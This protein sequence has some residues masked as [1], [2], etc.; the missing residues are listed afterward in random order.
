M[1]RR[2]FL[3]AGLAS[4]VVASAAAQE[5]KAEGE[6]DLGPVK[7]TEELW[8]LL[9]ALD[10]LIFCLAI[11][12]IKDQTV[13]VQARREI[14][15]YSSQLSDPKAEDAFNAALKSS[16]GQARAE[17]NKA[18]ISEAAKEIDALLTDIVSP[19]IRASVVHAFAR[20]SILL[21]A[22]AAENQSWWCHVY[23]FRKVRC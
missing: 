2:Q 18:A 16:E 14:Q 9:T 7:G 1:R 11:A 19:P 20:A 8:Y 4:A 21:V 13:I 3:L 12:V 15:P 5:Q 6:L 23:A 22:R 17:Q 10:T